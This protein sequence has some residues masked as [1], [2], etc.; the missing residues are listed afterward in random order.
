MNILIVAAVAEYSPFLDGRWRHRSSR[1]NNALAWWPGNAGSAREPGPP[2]HYRRRSG[3]SAEFALIIKASIINDRRPGSAVGVGVVDRLPRWRSRLLRPT[4]G[5][6]QLEGSK[7]FAKD[8]LARHKI[9]TA[10][11]PELY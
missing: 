10:S 2:G 8:F 1:V 11:L 9:P 5:A 3:G 7:A 4:P 6:A